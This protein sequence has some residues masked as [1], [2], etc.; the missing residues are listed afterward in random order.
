M[1]RARRALL[2][3]EHGYREALDLRDPLALARAEHE[4]MMAQGRVAR[5]DA[6][7]RRSRS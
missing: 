7:T 1:T 3:A 5:Q 4:L 6:N 2:C